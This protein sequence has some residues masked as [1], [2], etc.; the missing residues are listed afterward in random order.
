[1]NGESIRLSTGGTKEYTHSLVFS[2][3]TLRFPSIYFGSARQFKF[4]EAVENQ[5]EK[6]MRQLSFIQSIQFRH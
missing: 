4:S 1:M 2:H 6:L 3:R 5:C